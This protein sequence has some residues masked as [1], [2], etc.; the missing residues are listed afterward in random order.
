LPFVSANSQPTNRTSARSADSGWAARADPW[1]ASRVNNAESFGRLLTVVRTASIRRELSSNGARRLPYPHGNRHASSADATESRVKLRCG[2]FAADGI[3]EQRQPLGRNSPTRYSAPTA[4]W[5]PP[6]LVPARGVPHYDAKSCST[7]ETTVSM[8]NGFAMNESA[9]IRRA[10]SA[11]VDAALTTRTR[12]MNPCA[13]KLDV[14]LLAIHVW[15]H[16]VEHDH[17]RRLRC[18][19]LE[20]PRLPSDAMRTSYSGL[21]VRIVANTRA[22]AAPSSTTRT[23][24]VPRGDAC[25]HP[26]LGAPAP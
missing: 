11:P 21:S 10:C 20:G 26:S 14:E 23:E 19:H 22:W 16:D 18:R 3:A 8:S 17:F 7:A 24:C 25:M 15:Q 2:D 12:A 13:R 4:R 9:P 1:R 6:S 5:D